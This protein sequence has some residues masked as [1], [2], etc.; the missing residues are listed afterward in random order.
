MAKEI[1]F[2][3]ADK[4][5]EK[6][7]KKEFPNAKIFPGVLE[8]DA[9][10]QAC[11][12]AEMVSCFIYTN[13]TKEVLEKLPNLKILCTRSV[14]YNHIDVPTCKKKKITV[15][16]VPDYGSHIIA[17]H[18][19]ALILST[20]RHIPEADDRVEVGLFDYHGLRG[21]S[22]KDKT[23][24]IVGTGK[25]GSFVARIANGFGMKILAVDRHENPDL[26]RQYG[27]RY[28]QLND[29]LKKS[30]IISLHLPAL[31]ETHHI[32]DKKAFSIMKDGVVLVNTA[33]GELIYS[34]PLLDALKT[35]KVKYA[36]LDVMEHE[37]NFE[38]NK[39]LIGHP[40]AITTPHIAFYAEESMRNM[41]EDCF[42]SVEEWERGEE[43]E[44]II[45]PLRSK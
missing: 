34:D 29:L 10:V 24:G 21:M 32:L 42:Q 7:I 36:L 8:G 16:H 9:L 12:G 11:E 30:D 13:F 18:V 27:V 33:R 40:N 2:L 5:D 31:K 45:K 41:Y 20:F 35:G 38:E 28:V 44:H 3:E 26:A 15:C 43:P 23:M 22:L 6:L 37:K 17:E 39:E 1:V 14:G 19:F 25:I 4:E